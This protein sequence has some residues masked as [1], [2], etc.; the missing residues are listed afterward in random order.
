MSKYFTRWNWFCFVSRFLSKVIRMDGL[1]RILILQHTHTVACIRRRLYV[2]SKIIHVYTKKYTHTYLSCQIRE[3]FLLAS[4]TILAK[5]HIVN[6][7]LVLS[8]IVSVLITYPFLCLIGL[9]LSYIRQP[10]TVCCVG[11][12][13]SDCNLI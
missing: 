12:T 10:V 2:F 1:I 4:D 11:C 6:Q 13:Y 8:L 3:P 7:Y 9:I 5:A